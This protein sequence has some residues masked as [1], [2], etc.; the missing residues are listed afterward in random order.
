MRTIFDLTDADGRHR[1]GGAGDNGRGSP[2][3]VRIRVWS[4]AGTRCGR[5]LRAGYAREPRPETR[6]PSISWA[7][8]TRARRSARA[9]AA[10]CATAASSGGIVPDPDAGRDWRA[11]DR[12][13]RGRLLACRRAWARRRRGLVLLARTLLQ[14]LEWAGNLIRAVRTRYYAALAD[15]LAAGDEPAAAVQAARRARD[16]DRVD[17]RARAADGRGGW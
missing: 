6:T 1:G 2:A 17:L 5:H 4:G 13:R 10:P 15:R 11:A 16:R 9:A 7:C 8:G 12:R 3:V 14:R